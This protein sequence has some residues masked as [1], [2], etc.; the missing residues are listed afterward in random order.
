MTSFRAQAGPD[1]DDD[2]DDDDKVQVCVGSKCYYNDDS[3]SI[4]IET[5]YFAD[6]NGDPSEVCLN[7]DS[8]SFRYHSLSQLL[9]C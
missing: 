7:I 3:E 6:G 4:A 2:D 5:P 8:T 1:D 9:S